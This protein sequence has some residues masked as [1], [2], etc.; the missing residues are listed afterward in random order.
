MKQ[1]LNRPANPR[2]PVAADRLI[3]RRTALRRPGRCGTPGG[4]T[5]FEVRPGF[6]RRLATAVVAV[7]PAVGHAQ[8]RRIVVGDRLGVHALVAHALV[9]CGFGDVGRLARKGFAGADVVGA[10]IGHGT[11]AGAGLGCVAHEA[12]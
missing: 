6:F 10:T 11:A 12:S 8:R 4:F 5:Y 2:H 3:L 1:A 7:L 9:R